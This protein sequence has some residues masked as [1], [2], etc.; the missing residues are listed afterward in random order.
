[1]QVM[2][3]TTDGFVIAEE[4]LKL[5]GPGEFFG[6]RQSG[7]PDLDYSGYLPRHPD[8]GGRPQGGVRYS[9]QKPRIKG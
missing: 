7:V 8:P 6:T 3:E 2:S 9:C 5:R 4:D 1:M